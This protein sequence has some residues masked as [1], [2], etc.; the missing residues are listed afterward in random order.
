MNKAYEHARST[1]TFLT[2]I[3]L[4]IT[5]ISA[6]LSISISNKHQSEQWIKSFFLVSLNFCTN[7]PG[8]SSWR[9]LITSVIGMPAAQSAWMTRNPLVHIKIYICFRFLVEG[10]WLSFNDN[11]VTIIE[12]HNWNESIRFTEIVIGISD[13][14][15]LTAIEIHTDN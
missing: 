3:V 1:L 13:T 11:S 7:N 2:T 8:S 10:T 5:L 15:N 9:L 4:L 14:W 6:R 12:I